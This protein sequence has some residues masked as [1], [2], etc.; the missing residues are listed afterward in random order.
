MDYN[1]INNARVDEPYGRIDTKEKKEIVRKNFF[2]GG[3]NT[4]FHQDVTF[5]YNFPTIK[6]PLYRLDSLRASYR[7]EYDWITASLLAKDL[8]NTIVNGQT[9][10][11]NAD[12]NFEQLY[13]KSRFLKSSLFYCTGNSQPKDNPTNNNKVAKNNVKTDSL[14]KKEAR[15]LRKLK[16]KEK[17]KQ[18]GTETK[19]CTNSKWSS[20]RCC[21]STYFNKESGNSTH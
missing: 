13:N 16:R 9:K 12:L 20:K 1:A 6:F 4:H 5:T 2:D 21:K 8:G 17:E 7:A 11:L 18:E 10:N 3:R 15:K 14:S 19:F